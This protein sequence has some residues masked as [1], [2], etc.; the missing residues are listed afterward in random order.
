MSGPSIVGSAVIVYP[1]RPQQPSACGPGG[2][3]GGARSGA[4]TAAQQHDHTPSPSASS[5][6]SSCSEFPLRIN[7]CPSNPCITRIVHDLHKQILDGVEGAELE[8]NRYLTLCSFLEQQEAEGPQQ[9]QQERDGWV[10]HIVLDCLCG[11][12]AHAIRMTKSMYTQQFRLG[13]RSRFLRLRTS[14]AG[15]APRVLVQRAPV[16]L[17]IPLQALIPPRHTALQHTLLPDLGASMRMV[18]QRRFFTDHS[19]KHWVKAAAHLQV[20]G[21]AAQPTSQP[22][23]QQPMHSGS[24]STAESAAVAA[25]RTWARAHTLSVTLLH[26]S[27]PCLKRPKRPQAAAAEPDDRK[28]S[29]ISCREAP[30]PVD[31]AACI[32]VLYGTILKLYSL[33]AKVPTFKARVAMT[34]RL[35]E[36]S[37]LSSAEQLRFLMEHASL[38]RVC[39]MEYS[40]NALLDWLPCERELFLRTCPAMSTYL[41]IAGSMCDIFRWAEHLT[42]STPHQ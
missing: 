29:N 34:S 9:Q 39:F 31:V 7:Y 26:D 25:G 1:I 32:N 5:A 40:L 14:D 23:H 28:G 8:L 13:R 22:A 18:L 37:G 42:F 36:L 38:V 15:S 20:L 11:S 33:G 24:K 19:K 21:M 10:A 30:N 16:P 41:R 35:V 6:C 4:A 27:I 12:E 3:D 17:H 2:S